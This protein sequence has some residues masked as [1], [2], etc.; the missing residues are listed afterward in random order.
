MFTW[1]CVCGVG[2]KEAVTSAVADAPEWGTLSLTRHDAALATDQQRPGFRPENSAELLSKLGDSINNP[3]LLCPDPPLN[4]NNLFGDIRTAQFLSS[5]EEPD[6]SLYSQLPAFVK[7]LPGRLTSDDVKYLHAKGALSLPELG[8]Q[9]ALL[10]A[11]VEFV[12]PYMPLIE[13][14]D[15][16]NAIHSR[17]GL[18]GQISL[19]LYHAV[20]FAAT[21]F[22]DI[23]HL[24]EAGY[25]TRKAAR[26]FY[27]AKT[28]VS[29]RFFLSCWPI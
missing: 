1:Q 29:S 12:H 22:V 4:P 20:M 14:H 28:R 17:D 6:L 27:F 24:Q 21:A 2:V 5:L 8:L 23:R 3:R 10:Q 9:N 13:L 25:P 11:Y 19:F 7:P 18:C 16:L 15:F 26:K